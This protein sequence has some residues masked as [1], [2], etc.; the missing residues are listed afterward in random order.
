MAEKLGFV[1]ERVVLT[2][3][4]AN[5]VVRVDGA[6]CVGKQGLF[7]LVER[8]YLDAQVGAGLK[9]SSSSLAEFVALMSDGERAVLEAWFDR[10]RGGEG[11]V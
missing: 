9:V 1:L 6:V 4:E 10:L 2:A 8:L 5:Q 3:F 7:G 11:V